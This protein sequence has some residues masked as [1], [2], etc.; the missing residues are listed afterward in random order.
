M[1][2]LPGTGIRVA[3]VMGATSPVAI[4]TRLSGRATHFPPLSSLPLVH[5]YIMSYSEPDNDDVPAG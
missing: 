5:P 4:S 3:Y 1:K 2:W